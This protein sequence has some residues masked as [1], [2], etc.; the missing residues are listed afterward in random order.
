[1]LTGLGAAVAYRSWQATRHE[2]DGHTGHVLETG[3]GRTRFLGLLGMMT[4]LG[5]VAAVLFDTVVLFTVPLC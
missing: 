4:S 2:N 1:V 5:F 3:R